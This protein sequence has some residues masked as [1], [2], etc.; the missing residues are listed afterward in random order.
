MKKQYLGRRALLVGAGVVLAAPA[1]VRAQGQ[2]AGVALVIGNSKYHWEASLPNVRRDVPEIAKRFQALGLKTELLQDVGRD[3]L[4]RAVDAFTAS[5]RGANLAAFYFAGHGAAWGKDTF[6]VP[7]D[8]DLR[9][10]SAVKTLTSVTALRSG[11]DAAS[12]RL[13]AF[14]N[15]RNNPADGWRQQEAADLAGGF[16]GMTSAAKP[17]TLMLFS[18]A[19]GRVAVDG[20][21]GDL[22][23]FAATLLRQ[24]DAPSVD[25]QALPTSLRRDL[26]IATEGR[27]VA[28]DEN[29]YQQSFVLKGAA[30]KAPTAGR[31]SWASDPS[32]IIELPNAYAFAQQSDLLLPAGLIA[33]R[34]SGKSRD[35]QLIGSYKK[36]GRA[37]V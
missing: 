27:Q 30:A 14:D 15:C 12:H 25:L 24:L 36:I 19:P 3:A 13:L 8:A 2:T 34:P 23:P 31:S 17:D 16:T 10:P 1:I 33:H 4:Q 29:T 35:A 5:A 32:R 26:L 11:M 18:T 6:L 28:F 21:P 22:S 7:V 37:H 20:P 9:D